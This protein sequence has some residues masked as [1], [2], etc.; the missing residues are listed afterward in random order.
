MENKINLV[1]GAVAVALV[2][3]VAVLGWQ[4]NE[5][6]TIVK[7]GGGGTCP[8]GAAGMEGLRMNIVTVAH[9]DEFYNIKAEYPQFAGADAV[10]NGKIAAAVNGQIEAFKKEAKD[11]FDARNA[12]L[13][14][15]QVAKPNP[16]EP[17]DFVAVWTPGQFGPR[18]A[19]FMLDIYYFSGGAHGQ[20]QIF[21]FNY[22]L[23]NQKEILMGDFL[24]GQAN[25]EKLAKMAQERVTGQ[26]ESDGLPVNDSLKQMV[27]DGTQAK[28]ENYRNF[29]FGNGKLSIYFEQYQVAPGSE[30]TIKIDFY[31]KD[32]EQNGISAAF[33][34]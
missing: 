27:Q 33:L 10:F 2:A 16:D 4:N 32:L 19:S 15:G 21:A 13:P 1:L 24:G 18:V 5:L 20:D 3:V 26:L 23:Q 22:D 34:D 7:S 31:K 8:L 12:T 28:P 11:N 6:A 30:G 25:L 9:S 17:F 14:A 29:T